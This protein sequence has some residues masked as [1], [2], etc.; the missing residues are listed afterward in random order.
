LE[1]LKLEQL[2]PCIQGKSYQLFLKI[3]ELVFW[4]SL[5]YPQ[6]LGGMV[7][8]NGYTLFPE[9][10]EPL[11]NQNKTVDILALHGTRNSRVRMEP[12]FF[13]PA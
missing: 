5:H 7:S 8:L 13:L 10:E 12:I 3:I 1:A 6:R 11:P 9:K 2:W 4:G